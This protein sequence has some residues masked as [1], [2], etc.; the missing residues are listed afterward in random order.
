MG[1]GT[2]YAGVTLGDEMRGK[3]RRGKADNDD[4]SEI[5]GKRGEYLLTRGGMGSRRG[6][7]LREGKPLE[8]PENIPPLGV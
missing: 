7:V 2:L 5:V 3:G 6:D 1:L 8:Y 4:V